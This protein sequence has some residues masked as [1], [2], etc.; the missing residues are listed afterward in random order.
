MPAR[1]QSLDN[2]AWESDSGAVQR[3]CK[4]GDGALLVGSGLRGWVG[5]GERHDARSEDKDCRELHCGC[6]CVCVKYLSQ[7]VVDGL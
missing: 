4:H 3:I 2:G 1:T 5:D 6:V 7:G